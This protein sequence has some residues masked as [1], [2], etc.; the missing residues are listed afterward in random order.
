[1]TAATSP[2][3]IAAQGDA[4]VQ[5]AMRQIAEATEELYKALAA[6]GESTPRLRTV[7]ASAVGPGLCEQAVQQ[8]L[9]LWSAP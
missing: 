8:G 7:L 3:S 5:A 1:M 4:R 2:V 6:V 9:A